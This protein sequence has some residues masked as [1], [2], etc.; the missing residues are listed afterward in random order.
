[1]FIPSHFLVLS[2]S[3]V[4]D[5]LTPVTENVFACR[6]GSAADTQAITDVVKY[7]A[8]LLALERGKPVPV[9]TVAWRYKDICYEYREGRTTRSQRRRHKCDTFIFSFLG[10]N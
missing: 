6:S 2:T 4:T 7:E 9:H 1:M 8:G 3:R 5:K 10:R